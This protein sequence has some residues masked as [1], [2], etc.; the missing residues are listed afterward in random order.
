MVGLDILV[1][2]ANI[3]YLISYSVRDIFWLRVLSVIGAMILLP[4]YYLQPAPLWAPI[5]WN[6]FF[7][8]IN[9]F[10]IVRLLLERRPVPFTDAER[11][12]YE[13]ALRNFSER[14]AYN[15]L[16]MGVAKSVPAGS[17]LLTQG[18]PVHSLS[19][20]VDGEIDVEM[21]GNHVDTLGEGRFLGGTAFLS[22]DQ[23]F[24]ARVTVTARTPSRVIEWKLPDLT[25]EL[26][27]QPDLAISIEASL[28][29]EISRF[30]QTA[31]LQM[32]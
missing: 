8:G 25:E 7:T 9:I 19:L 12:L 23:G 32:A 13:I 26:Q 6:L 11:H 1:N 20:I 18:S 30:L 10:W 27:K 21:N 5:G 3:F 17:S 28:G 24:A 4:Y 29:L 16:R 15:L 2:V 14:D 22:K 31:R